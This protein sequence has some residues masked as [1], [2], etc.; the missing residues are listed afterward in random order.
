MKVHLWLPDLFAG[1]GG[2]QMFSAALLKG[3]EAN[4]SVTKVCAFVK[5]DPKS[6]S[7]TKHAKTCVRTYGCKLPALLHTIRFGSALLGHGFLERPD[8]IISSLLNFSVIAPILRGASSIPYWTVAHGVEAWGLKKGRR[9]SAFWASN[10]ILPVSRFTMD[11]VLR[12]RP[13]SAR[14]SIR[15]QV[16]L[17]PNTFDESKFKIAPKPPH[18]LSRYGIRPDEKVILTIT[19]LAREEGYKGYDTVL[20]AL[21]SVLKSSPKTKYLIGGKGSDLGRI[22]Q[23]VAEKGLRDH[24][25]LPGFI[26]D[27]ELVEHYN[28]CD[29]FVMPSKKEGFGIVFLEAL[30]CGKPV[31]AGNKDGSVDA[32]NGGEL[33]VLVD[34][35]DVA[36]ISERIVGIL[37]R[38]DPNKNLF[39]PELLRSRAVELFGFSRFR[40]RLDLLLA[41][42]SRNF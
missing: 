14:G 39:Q 40:E 32:L 33:G 34:P 1:T 42:H 21:P 27:K 35:D 4:N 26:P 24:V 17:F 8:L 19:R 31:L 22:T 30:G 7:T 2:I 28:L 41:E 9:H 3:I 11:S 38:T 5:N 6:F 29:L 18:L 25:I 15:E 13:M 23:M 10:K 16:R 20:L 37:N 36:Q 12:N